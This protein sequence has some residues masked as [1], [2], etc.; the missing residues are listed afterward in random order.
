MQDS[1]IR[2]LMTTKPAKDEIIDVRSHRMRME[3]NWKMDSKSP[4]FFPPMLR[5]Y[6]VKR[7]YHDFHARSKPSCP[8]TIFPRTNRWKTTCL[9]KR[10]Q[11]VRD[12]MGPRLLIL[13][14]HYQQDEVIAL[15]DLRGDSYQLASLAAS[16]EECRA[17]AFC[18]VHFMAETADILAN[19]PERLAER[20]G[21]RVQRDSARPGRRLLAG[22]HGRYRT[23]RRLLAAACR[24]DRHRRRDADHLRQF[25]GRFEGVLRPA[26]RH[27]LH[28]GQRPGG[29]GLGLCPTQPRAVLS[30][31]A[32]GP[33]H[34]QGDGHSVGTDAA[35]G[36]AARTNSAATRP[37]RSGKAA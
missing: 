26:R 2:F 12:A 6:C 19:R 1:T 33:Q 27:C 5:I 29:L 32:P 30:R 20:G 24:G 31:S 10:I 17:I 14:H 18:G 15:S 25:G 23:G 28:V 11:Q 9:T 37:S 7:K 16:H 22:R 34:R 4:L 8:P 21:E 35:L 13:G 36:S 3:M